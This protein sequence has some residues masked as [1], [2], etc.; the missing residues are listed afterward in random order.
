MALSQAQQAVLEA[1]QKAFNESGEVLG[2]RDLARLT[3]LPSGTVGAALMRLRHLG[4]IPDRAPGDSHVRRTRGPQEQA[5]AQ[6]QTHDPIVPRTLRPEDV[7]FSRQEKPEEGS[8]ISSLRAEIESLRAQLTWATHADAEQG[9]SGGTM[10]VDVSDWHLHDRNHLPTALASCEAKTMTVI[11]NFRP[12]RLRIVENGDVIPGRGIYKEQA[13]E[14]ILPKTD[15]QVSA[16]AIRFDEFVRR[17]AEAAGIDVDDVPVYKTPGNHDY[18]EKEPTSLPF[19]YLLRLLGL[20]AEFCG[21][22]KVLNLADKGVHNAIFFH[23]YG[24]SRHSPSSPSLIDETI[25]LVLKLATEYGYNGRRSIR[26]ASHGHTHWMAVGMERAAGLT[27]DVTG[28]FQRFERVQQ[29]H[30]ERP[31]G[32]ICYASPAGS[33][34]VIPIPVAPDSRDLEADMTDPV[35]E[36]KN[37]GEAKRCLEAFA[38]AAKARG[39]ASDFWA[40]ARENREAAG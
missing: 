29:G 5:A 23:G 18:S 3:G 36:A 10:T 30:N 39:I 14:A 26:R 25:K 22:Y 7:G 16:A 13:L 11:R 28:G 34:D 2:R 9:V 15:Q 17:C 31:T 37:Y 19:V 6:V 1:Y 12:R 32:W 20:K 35:L 38:E 8:L 33:E 21:K 24:H 40:Q 4:M 27:F